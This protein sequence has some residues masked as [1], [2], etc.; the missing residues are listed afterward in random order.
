[1]TNIDT[2]DKLVRTALGMEVGQPL[3]LQSPDSSHIVLFFSYL[4]GNVYTHCL[5]FDS[6][7]VIYEN[8]LLK[9]LS[10]EMGGVPLLMLPP[11]VFPQANMEQFCAYYEEK[12]ASVGIVSSREQTRIFDGQPIVSYRLADQPDPDGFSTVGQDALNLV[13][14]MSSSNR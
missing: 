8:K 7:P 6:R 5:Y 1:M 14:A 13:R 9:R 2:L 4:S 10:M 11:F 3:E 12:L